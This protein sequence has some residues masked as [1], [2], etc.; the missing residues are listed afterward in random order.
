MSFDNKEWNHEE[1]CYYFLPDDVRFSR[2]VRIKLQ[3]QRLQCLLFWITNFS[4]TP[5]AHRT[6]GFHSLNH[7]RKIMPG[8][9]CCAPIFQPVKLKL[10][11]VKTRCIESLASHCEN[12]F[13]QQGVCIMR[14]LIIVLFLMMSGFVA[15]SGADCS[16]RDCNVFCFG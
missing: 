2:S 10:D 4:W 8:V 16:S 13:R 15:L 1:V 6:G 12:V 11:P 3:C 14:K 9:V 5:I 7:P